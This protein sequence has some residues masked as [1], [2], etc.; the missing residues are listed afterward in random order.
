MSDMDEHTTRELTEFEK[1]LLETQEVVMVRRKV[2]TCLTLFLLYLIISSLL[3][4]MNLI[5]IVLGTNY[6]FCT[7]I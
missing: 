3:H 7:C 4:L 2:R 6:V 5:A 1:H